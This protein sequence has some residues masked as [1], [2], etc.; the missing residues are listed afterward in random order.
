M[1]EANPALRSQELAY[2]TARNGETTVK[3]IRNGRAYYIHSPYDPA[4]EA[5][6]FAEVI[7][8][9]GFLHIVIGAGLGYLLPALRVRATEDDRFVLIEPMAELYARLRASNVLKNHGDERIKVFQ[10]SQRNELQRYLGQLFHNGYLSRFRVDVAPNY[11]QIAGDEIAEL[12]RWLLEL[13]RIHQVGF[14]TLISFS[15]QWHYNYLLN[16]RHA[17]RSTPFNEFKARW[18]VPAII[19]AAGPSLAHALPELHWLRERALLIAAGSAITTLVRYGVRP[20][21][22]V[23]VDGMPANHAHFQRVPDLDVPLFYSPMIYYKILRQYRGPKVVF[24]VEQTPFQKWYNEKLGFDPGFAHTGPSVANVALDLARQMTSGPITLVGQD[25]GYTG[26]YSHAPDH[27][28]RRAL[29]AF[30]QGGRK[31]IEVEANDGSMLTTDYVYLSMK[32]WFESFVAVHQLGDRVYNSTAQG[33]KIEGV[34]F[35]PLSEF[36]ERYADQKVD[37]DRE[38]KE[39]IQ[40]HRPPMPPKLGLDEEYALLHAAS[41]PIRKAR[42]AARE[43]H[44]LIKSERPDV[45]QVQKVVRRLDRLDAEI[46]SRTELDELLGYLVSVLHERIQAANIES[47]SDDASVRDEKIAQKNVRFYTDLYRAVRTTRL[48]LYFISRRG[49][50]DGTRT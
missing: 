30:V 36:A 34:P 22:V 13:A 48:L 24:Q 11:R 25:L 27:P 41:V 5:Q 4:R 45:K 15:L 20:H 14:N 18:D 21:L 33:A 23:S 26:G 37:L 35:I 44:D 29:D 19:L 8:R 16:M 2:E 31:L 46:R 7:H 17:A 39:V 42:K 1:R 10:A 9:P 50:C 40:K 47:D 38:I 6:R 3:V 43:L 12:E 49:D 32:R 28:H